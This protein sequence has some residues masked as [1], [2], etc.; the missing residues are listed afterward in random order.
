MIFKYPNGFPFEVYFVTKDLLA[1]LAQQAVPFNNLSKIS[2]YHEKLTY[3]EV[4]LFVATQH[5]AA[6]VFGVEMPDPAVSF[7]EGYR[8]AMV[9]EA[10][11]G[12]DSEAIHRFLMESTSFHSTLVGQVMLIGVGEMESPKVS[13]W[14]HL[15]AKN[16]AL[17]VQETI[18]ERVGYLDAH[19]GSVIKAS[20][21]ELTM[22]EVYRGIHL[23]SA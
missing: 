22:A 7:G 18:Y 11:N 10:F 14:E 19:F 4:A 5:A 16:I 13:T 1:T 15:D 17:A 9:A 6:K 2:S 12:I 21:G 23:Q 8:A 20:L 3:S